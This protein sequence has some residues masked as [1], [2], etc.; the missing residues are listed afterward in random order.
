VR[1]VT[2]GKRYEGNRPLADSRPVYLKPNVQI[3]PLF[4]QWYAWAHLVAPATAALNVA[5][6]HL[7]VMRSFVSAP[8]IHAA[9]VRNPETHGGPFVDLDPTRVAEVEAL[10][11]RTELEQ[12]PLIDF[13]K[14]LSALN[15]LL[16]SEATGG[17]LTQLYPRVSDLLRG[18]VELTYD[19]NGRPGFRLL[20]GLLYRSPF[21]A[22]SLQSLVLS[23]AGEGNDRP[24]VFSTPRLPQSTQVQLHMPFGDPRLDRLVAL[25]F[26][27]EPLAQVQEWLGLDSRQVEAFR[28]FTTPEPPLGPAGAVE[29][30][31]RIRYLGHASLLFETPD[32]CVLTDPLVGYLEGEAVR[33]TDLPARIDVVLLTHT[34]SDH[35]VL[36]TLLQLR[37]RIGTII[38]PRSS[39]SLEDPSLRLML[40]NIGFRDVREIDDLE[41]IAIPGGEIVG[42]PFLGEHGDLNIRS[43]TGHLIR[44]AGKQVLCTAD[45]AN[46]DPRLYE[47]VQRAC[48]DVDALFLGMEC[49][50]APMSWM[51]GSLAMR[52]VDRKMD[53][54]R[55]L[56]ASDASEAWEMVR[57]FHARNVFV[58][59]MGQEEWLG[60]ITSIRYTE[61]SKPIIESNKLLA[62]CQSHGIRAQRLYGTQDLAL[63]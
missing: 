36:E 3:E 7:K 57:C 14:A 63:T 46:L 21:Y 27:A 16:L 20:E 6:H 49:D 1:A 48:G 44:L 61:A 23:L 8:Q 30:G 59:A 39:G 4:N 29:R 19:L 45:S 53:Q 40:L 33:L 50:G 18:Y 9:A 31:L 12:K 51:Y 32:V 56:C 38:V 15:E 22:P 25:R 13:A 43:K 60:F 24:F 41:S 55:R 35:V 42:I 54:S 28:A 11:R 47:H 34:H 2:E 17:S 52:R 37:G 58:Y 62:T 26:A 10:L 5:N